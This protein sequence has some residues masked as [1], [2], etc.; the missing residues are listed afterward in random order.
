MNRPRH[1]LPL[2]ALLAILQGG[3]ALTPD[4][5]YDDYGPAVYVP[6]P[7]PLYEYPGFAPYPGYIWISGYWQW[8]GA[9]YEWRPGRWE[10][11]RPGHAWVP[12]RWER[13]GDHWR[14]SGGRWLPEGQPPR[15][16]PRPMPQVQQY[17]AQVPQRDHEERQPRENPPAFGRS[18]HQPMVAPMREMPQAAPARPQAAPQAAPQFMQP[19][20]ASERPERQRHERGDFPRRRGPDNN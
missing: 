20:Q 9:R 4:P 18:A 6:P 1:L 13:Q 15:P 17:P 7:A 3:C 8:L 10:A 14:S 12:Y 19:R 11:P 2:I 16:V 5:Y